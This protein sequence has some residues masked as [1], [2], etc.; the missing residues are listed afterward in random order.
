MRDGSNAGLRTWHNLALARTSRLATGHRCLFRIA[1]HSHI[2][3]GCQHLGL[4]A[5]PWGCARGSLPRCS[6]ACSTLQRQQVRAPCEMHE[7]WTPGAWVAGI[8]SLVHTRRSPFVIRIF[9]GS[10]LSCLQALPT[11][12]HMLTF[13]SGVSAAAA[14]CRR[15]QPEA[16]RRC[17]SIRSPAVRHKNAGSEAC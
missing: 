14:K 8:R 9:D 13:A 6:R 15:S 12:W 3:S 2:A 7:I 1:I 10:L 17:G 5:G 16:L 4:G 11:N